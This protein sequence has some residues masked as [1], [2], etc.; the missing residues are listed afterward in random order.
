MTHKIYI[1]SFKG[2]PQDDWLFCA[3]TGFNRRGSEIIL[4][5][6][7]DEVPVN[8]LNIVIAYIEDTIKYLT[9]LNIKPIQPLNIP[10]Q[11]S[12]YAKRKVSVMSL[13][14]FLPFPYS[15]NLILS[16]RSFHLGYYLNYLLRIGCFMEYLRIH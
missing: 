4:F 12:S 2:I 9:R 8:K 3:Y 15:S 1:Q 10:D 5:E 11:L 14:S 13:K 16:L 7:I 6:N